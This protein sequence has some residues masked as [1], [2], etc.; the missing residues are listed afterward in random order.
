VSIIATSYGLSGGPNDVIFQFVSP[1]LDQVM[2]LFHE[3]LLLHAPAQKQPSRKKPRSGKALDTVEF[4]KTY[5][6]NC[7]QRG[8]IRFSCLRLAGR[9]LAVQ[10]LQVRKRTA[11]LLTAGN[12][13]RFRDTTLGTL[14]MGE[15]I[16]RL[17]HEQVDRLVVPNAAS[18]K[19]IGECRQI[20]CVD[21]TIYPWSSRSIVAIMM[22]RARRASSVLIGRRR[23]ERSASE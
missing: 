17:Q 21:V 6:F 3:S 8:E 19:E 13:E 14:L 5:A 1:S 11:W 15:T 20:P 10:M 16:R 22:G 2:Q 7:A 4:L 18:M 12:L 9:L 23:G